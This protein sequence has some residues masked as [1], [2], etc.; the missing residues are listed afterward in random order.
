M[1]GSLHAARP[2]STATSSHV[3]AAVPAVENFHTCAPRLVAWVG[4]IAPSSSRPRTRSNAH[5]SSTITKSVV[6]PCN[7]SGAGLNGRNVPPE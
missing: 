2:C 7:A 4:T 5:A 3:D 1:R 6:L